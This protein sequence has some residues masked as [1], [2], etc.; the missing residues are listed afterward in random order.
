MA[1]PGKPISVK[2]GQILPNK[3]VSGSS[4]GGRHAMHEMLDFSTRHNIVAWTEKLPMDSVNTA[5]DRLRENDVRYRFV[6]EK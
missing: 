5:L 2:I 3:Q 6:L 4:I 1:V